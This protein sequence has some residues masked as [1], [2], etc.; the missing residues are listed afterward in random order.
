MEASLSSIVQ[1]RENW[2]KFLDSCSAMYKYSFDEQLLIHAQRPETKACTSFEFWTSEKKMNRHIK[3]GT[4]GIALLNRD[5]RKLYYVYA[6]EDTETRANG[7]SKNPEDYLWKMTEQHKETVAEM[8]RNRFG[9]SENPPDGLVKL[10]ELAV[11]KYLPVYNEKLKENCREL[12]VPYTAEIKNA[13]SQLINES[14]IY[15]TLKRCGYNLDSILSE[16]AFSS[17]NKFDSR[18][19]ALIGQT[20]NQAA[21]TAVRQVE[22]VVG[23]PINQKRSNENE[24][25]AKEE[26]QEWNSVHSGRRNADISS[27]LRGGQRTDRDRQIRQ[28][29]K[30]YLKEHKDVTYMELLLSNRL[31]A[32]LIETDEQAYRMKED[33][34]QKMAAAEGTNE[35]LKAKDQMEWVR[36]MNSYQMTAEEVIMKELIYV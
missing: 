21:N 26:N 36:R 34:M 19:T 25:I 7:K 33:I 9:I 20:L 12:N 14:A 23:M 27:V 28:S 18:F 29:K 22:K 4:E 2:R 31:T 6:V 5:S 15:I 3:R 32:H 35:E 11:K 16:N 17:L 13:F 30:Q 8:L 24:R 10:A 1:N